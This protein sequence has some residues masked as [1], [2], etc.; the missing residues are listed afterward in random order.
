[1][2]FLGRLESG[3]DADVQLLLAAR[4]PAAAAS[5]K[6]GRLFDFAQPEE[7]AEELACGGFATN[8][9]GNLDVVNTTD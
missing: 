7:R 4:Q 5:A 9:R 8:W 3:F 2:R 1:M 6:G